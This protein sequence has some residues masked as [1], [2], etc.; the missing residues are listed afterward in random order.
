MS[1]PSK[2]CVGPRGLGVVQGR[3]LKSTG[4]VVVSESWPDPELSG[5]WCL[6]CPARCMAS[7]G[8]YFPDWDPNS[9]GKPLGYASWLQNMAHLPGVSVVLRVLRSWMLKYINW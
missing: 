6:S 5:A 8:M 9:C 1:P 2:G 7:V 4:C 3:C